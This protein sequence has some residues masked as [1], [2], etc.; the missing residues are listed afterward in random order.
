MGV[1]WVGEP[2][3]KFAVEETRKFEQDARAQK[4]TAA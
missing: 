2:A 1:A 4:S 3:M